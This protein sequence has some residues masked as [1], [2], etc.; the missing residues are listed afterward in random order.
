MKESME[1]L[2]HHFKLF[3]EG[4][5]VP[6][7]ETYSAIEAPRA[8]WASTSS[9]TAPI[10]LTLPHPRSWFCSSGRGRFHVTTSL[11]TG[12]GRD[13]RTMDLVFGEVDR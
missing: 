5:N 11:L 13:H 1:A 2:I 7:G 8:R 4:Y 12:Y 9:A 6:P 3:S 10:G